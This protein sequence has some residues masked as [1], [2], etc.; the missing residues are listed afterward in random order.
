MSASATF[1]IDEYEHMITRGAFAGPNEKRIELIRGELRMMSPQG[2]EHGE[3]VGTLDDWSHDVID[4]QKIKI[5]VQSSVEIPKFDAQPEPDI[6]LAESKSYARR[7]P[8][9]HEIFL[10][11]E[12]ADTSL[13]YDLGEKCQLYAEAGIRDYWVFDIPNRLVHV[14]RDPSKDGYELRDRFST[15]DRLIPKLVTDV[16][17]NVDETFACLDD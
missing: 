2:A 13:A 10:L 14:F 12:V 6:V 15:H 8:R 7:R 11:I 5:R 9:P 3:L 4:R 17:L 16:S 1:T